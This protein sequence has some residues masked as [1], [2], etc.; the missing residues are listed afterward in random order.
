MN[1]LL[2]TSVRFCGTRQ[3]LRDT[4][5]EFLLF[6]KCRP[7]FSSAYLYFH[8]NWLS[9]LTWA[10]FTHWVGSA[11]PTTT[12]KHLYC[13]AVRLINLTPAHCKI[14]LLTV[15]TSFVQSDWTK[16]WSGSF[17]WVWTTNGSTHYVLCV[18]TKWA[19]DHS[20]LTVGP[21]IEGNSVQF[22]CLRFYSQL[23]PLHWIFWASCLRAWQKVEQV[24]SSL[25]GRR[26]RDVE[27]QHFGILKE[28]W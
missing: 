15:H 14:K 3:F 19:A 6:F 4:V 21:V 26:R 9:W 18:L 28:R 10:R 11:S 22:T 23:S 1:L 5:K 16:P 2:S 12:V 13:S 24:N 8:H 20:N 17:G 27:K 25:G 7:L